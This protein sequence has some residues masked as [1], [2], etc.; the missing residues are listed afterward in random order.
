MASLTLSLNTL[1]GG[2]A[3]RPHRHNAAAI[4]LVVQGRSSFSL[5]DGA[6]AEWSEW[7]TLVTPPCAP[8]SHHN[9]GSERALF[10]IVQDGGFHYQARTMGFAFLDA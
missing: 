9:G 3:Q 2:A 8:H 1:P 10:L 5:I 4:T 6:R 7:A